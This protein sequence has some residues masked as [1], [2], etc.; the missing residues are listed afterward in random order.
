MCGIASLGWAGEVNRFSRTLEFTL[1]G[2]QVV[3]RPE[4]TRLDHGQA[5][6][7]RL[8]NKTSSIQCLKQPLTGQ[9]MLIHPGQ[10]RTWN[11]R[12]EWVNQF[13]LRCS[14]SSASWQGWLFVD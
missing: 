12:F 2:Q 3:L 4:T 11:S 13:D 7:F 5:Y 10:T 14:D 9:D 8:I 1:R 6:S